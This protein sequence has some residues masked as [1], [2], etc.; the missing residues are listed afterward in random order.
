MLGKTFNL[1]GHRG[2]RG[3]V[4]ENTLPSFEAALDAGVSSIETDLHLTRDGV[5]VICHD[6]YL[7]DPP[8]LVSSL[9]AAE[10]QRFCLD[11]NPDPLRFPDQRPTVAPLAAALAAERGIHPFAP[12][13]LD[14]LF[15][16]VA[17]YAADFERTAEQRAVAARVVLDLELKRVP[18]RPEFIGDAFDGRSPGLLE[19]RVLES[20]GRHRML[21]R[22]VVRS[23]DH[24][25][26]AVLTRSEPRLKG[27]V[28]VANNVPVDLVG[29]VKRAGASVYCPNPLFLDASLVDQLHAAGISVLPWTVNDP[30]DWE[31]LLAWGVDGITTD[32][33]DRLATWL[34][35]RDLSH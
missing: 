24:R 4:P 30:P 31:R 17:A 34:T 29:L 15:A 3:L 7:G 21:A 9:T 11:R 2:A 18:F 26:V 20:I 19:Q 33:P 25:C 23:F 5:V 16:F 22:S 6:P 13:T 35:D 10:L 28:L 32:Y 27:A 12:P 1:Q 8:R 14:D